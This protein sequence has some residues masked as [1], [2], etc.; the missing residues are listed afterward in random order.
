MWRRSSRRH[1]Y[2]RRISSSCPRGGV[3]LEIV[4]DKPWLAFCEYL[5]DLRSH[6]S[7]NVD[8]PIPAITLLEL[9]L[10]ETYPGHHAEN[11]CEEHLL[12]RDQGLLEETLV[13]VPTPQSLV[14]EGIAGLAATL[15][16]EGDRGSALAAVLENAVEK[17]FDLAHDLAVSAAHEPCG[18]A[19]VN[20]A[21][22][23]HEEGAGE[24]E[25]R[26]YLERWM[27][28]TPELASHSIR[29]MTEPTSRTYVMTYS[30]GLELCRA[31][32]AGEPERVCRLLTEQIRVGELLAAAGP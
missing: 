16:L 8:L 24:A 1:G 25:V 6:I 29:F 3:V 26:S 17:E 30:V 32:V 18:Q 20:A 7:V 22:M 31:Y 13:L 15:P 12:V 4:H 28:S 23:L 21:L 14:A 2:K 5:G 27:L 10:H 9:T 11:S 19:A